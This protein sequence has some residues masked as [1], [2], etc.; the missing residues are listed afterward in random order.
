VLICNGEWCCFRVYFDR[1]GGFLPLA[2]DRVYGHA[3]SVEFSLEYSTFDAQSLSTDVYFLGVIY[4][5]HT[6]PDVV[7]RF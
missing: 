1:V 5:N 6:C 7:F 3:Y 4:S 2:L